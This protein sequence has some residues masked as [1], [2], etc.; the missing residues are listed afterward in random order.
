M[1]CLKHLT[2]IPGFR[3]K[4]ASI[5]YNRT[6]YHKVHYLPP[7][8]NGYVFFELLL[9]RVFASTSKNTMNDMDKRFN[10]H[11]WCCTITSNIHNTQVLTFRKSS[12]VGQLVC[13]NQNCDFLSRSSKRNET[14]WFGQANTPFNLGHSP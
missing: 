4:L 14:K 1:Q 7:S 5:D 6:A 9:N 11:T 3:N 10:G 12:C 13:N 8:S 2:S